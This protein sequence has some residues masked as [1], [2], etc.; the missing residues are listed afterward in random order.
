LRI[1]NKY[2]NHENDSVKI[3]FSDPNIYSDFCSILASVINKSSIKRKHPGSG[4][5]MAPGYNVITYF[6]IGDKKYS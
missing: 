6:E 2:Q 4:C 3:P 5:V 1:F